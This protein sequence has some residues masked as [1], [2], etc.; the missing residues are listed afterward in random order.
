MFIMRLSF[1]CV[2]VCSLYG[3]ETHVHSPKEL[4][5]AFIDQV[6]ALP[7]PCRPSYK[8]WHKEDDIYAAYNASL[9]TL[10]SA[11]VAIDPTLLNIPVDDKGNTFLH[12]VTTDGLSEGYLCH[13]I[14][15]CSQLGADI[16][17]VNHAGKLSIDN[18]YNHVCCG[19]FSQCRGAIYA[20]MK[21][22]LQQKI[23]Q[24]LTADEQR[25]AQ[26][27]VTERK[28]ITTFTQVMEDPQLCK[29]PR[30]EQLKIAYFKG[31]LNA[32][33]RTH[34]IN[35]IPHFDDEKI[36]EHIACMRWL[37]QHGAHADST[38]SHD[39]RELLSQL[40]FPRYYAEHYV[41][42]AELLLEHGVDVEGDNKN[43]TQ[44]GFLARSRF[45]RADQIA[46][47]SLLVLLMRRYGADIDACREEGVSARQLVSHNATWLFHHARPEDY[48]L[49]CQA[50]DFK[51]PYAQA[52]QPLPATASSSTDVCKEAAPTAERARK[53]KGLKKLLASAHNKF[54]KRSKK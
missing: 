20:L 9:K 28:K 7:K 24:G 21:K 11:A 39:K 30:D 8:S 44:L 54:S 14:E 52:P 22:D 19:D 33:L 12:C 49:F 4:Q 31:Y 50:W 47:P 36:V 27:L 41:P 3:G 35:T 45:D 43:H 42:L 15:W 6:Q 23:T 13:L 40:L 34:F 1:L 32:Q 5:Q 29:L 53:K 51:D 10:I 48:R 17:K 26:L 38:G 25:I 46:I 16:C 2:A 18:V 37:L